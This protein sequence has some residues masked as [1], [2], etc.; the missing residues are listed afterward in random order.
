M[1]HNRRQLLAK[2]AYLYYER[3]HTQAQIAKELNIYRTTISRML[4]QARQLGIV[5]I[6][7]ND[8]NSDLLNNEILEKIQ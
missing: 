6:K 1:S 3:D 7:I 8:F 4:K 5:E 2:V